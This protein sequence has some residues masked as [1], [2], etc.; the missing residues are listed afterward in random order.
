[1][2]RIHLPYLFELAAALEPL[3]NLKQS[4]INDNYPLWRA[5]SALRQLL[6]N[7]VYSSELRNCVQQGNR[8][9]ELM[10][11]QIEKSA[12]NVDAEI[13]F[14]DCRLIG[15]NYEQFKTV[16]VSEIGVWPSYFVNRKGGYDTLTLLDAGETLFPE[17]LFQK[18]PEA[19]F[20]AREASK[21]LAFECC[22]AAGF[23]VYRC[24]ESVLR[25]YWKEVSGGSPDPKVR[26]IG[27]YVRALEKGKFGDP[28]VVSALDQI[29]NLHRNPLIHPEVALN[30]NETI[31]SF[32]MVRSAIGAML[33]ALPDAPSTTYTP[34]P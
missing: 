4:R 34:T 26:S 27:V 33:Q 31:D 10:N 25:R 8:L 12:K 19:I 20:D 18:V 1:M 21:A 13:S 22:T 24:L 11:E 30:M 15:L 3:E 29:N 14:V 32:G 23:H 28:K 9:L 7:S 16:F 6:T 17:T 5:E 2:I